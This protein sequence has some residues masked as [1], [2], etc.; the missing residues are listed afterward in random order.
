MFNAKFI[1]RL[2]LEQ[3]EQDIEKNLD[4]YSKTKTWRHSP[5][6][7][8]DQIDAF[9]MRYE[10]D[11]ELEGTET[12]MEVEEEVEKLN[13]SFRN[14]SLYSLL[15]EQDDPAAEFEEEEIGAAEEEEEADE[16]EEAGGDEEAGEEEGEEEGDEEAEEAEE[17]EDPEGNEAKDKDVEAAE[18]SDMPQPKINIDKFT[19]KVVRLYENPDTL[20]NIQDVIIN[21]TKNYLIE[22]YGEKHAQRFIDTLRDNFGLDFETGSDADD[23]HDVPM[24]AGAW[25]GGGGGA[26]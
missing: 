24:Q 18:D 10:K 3:L 21:R 13:E 4:V 12:E 19:Q 22:N 6:S 20:L 23:I 5:T 14:K 1:R 25:G 9:L 16:E 11:S 17:E 15:F 26:V 8:D 2:I 7:V